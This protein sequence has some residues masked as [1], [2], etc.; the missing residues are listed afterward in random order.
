MCKF[1][2]A[3]ITWKVNG[4]NSDLPSGQT[5][6]GNITTSTLR[7][8]ALIEYNQTVV[9]CIGHYNGDMIE[10]NLATLSYQGSLSTMFEQNFNIN[11]ML[12]CRIA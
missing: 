10:S 1:E 6:S 12:P 8:P 4:T 9:Q 3:G 5:F 2:T 7:V 11:F